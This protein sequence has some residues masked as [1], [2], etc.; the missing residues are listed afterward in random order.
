LEPRIIGI[1]TA[2][3]LHDSEA[4]AALDDC[5][6]AELRA[7]GMEPSQIPAILEDLRAEIGRRRGGR[8][9]DMILTLRLQ[10]D[11]GAWE[12]AMADEREKVWL[13]VLERGRFSGWIDIEAEEWPRLSPQLRGALETGT[14]RVLLSRHDFQ[15]C[16]PIA[17]LRGQLDHVKGRVVSGFKAAVTCKSRGELLDLLA[18]AR[19]AAAATPNASVFSMGEAGRTSRVLAPLLGC[20]F[21][22]G[23]L[24]GSAV[25]PGQLSARAMKD[26]YRGLPERDW[27]ERPLEELL[28]WAEGRLSGG[29]IA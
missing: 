4:I 9:I 23:F 22:Y 1:V 24:T 20:P 16:P 18:F 11:G 17:D 15:A 2:R 21:T 19:E 13:A 25:A 6:H 10:R 29:A 27:S 8:G 12:D 5:S 3:N 28:D 7:D 14:C 26:F